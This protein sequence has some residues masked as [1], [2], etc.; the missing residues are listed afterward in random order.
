MLEYT[1][2]AMALLELGKNQ[3]EE[4]RYMEQLC[5]IANLFDTLPELRQLFSHPNIENEKKTEIIK[6]A[7]ENQVDDMVYR[8]LIVMNEHKMLSHMKEIYQSYVSCYEEKYDIEVVKVMSAIELDE[9][10]IEK[11][12]KVLK[13]KLNKDI[14]ISVEVDPSL[15]AGLKVQTKDMV[16]DNTIVSKIDAMKEAMNR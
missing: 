3:E 1:P 2:Y 13:E 8:F 6:S 4:K 15:I 9:E 11:L 12:T 16:M 10:Q 5:E 14:K 7:F